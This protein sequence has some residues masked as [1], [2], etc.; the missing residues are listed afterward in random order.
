MQLTWRAGELPR[1]ASSHF[2]SNGDLDGN[3]YFDGNGDIKEDSRS[4]HFRSGNFKFNATFA[5]KRVNQHIFV[6]RTYFGGNFV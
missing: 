5:K 1:S 6:E 4:T 3:N 2:D